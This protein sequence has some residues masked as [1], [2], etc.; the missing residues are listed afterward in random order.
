MAVDRSL[1][2]WS[3]SA[4]GIGAMVGAGIFALL[5]QAALVAGSE[6]YVAF[7]LGGVVAAL[8]G[9]SYAKLAAHYPDAGGL[10]AYF[11]TA[12]GTGRV[13]GTLALIYLI[14]LAATVAMVAKAFGAYAAPLIGGD[15]SQLWINVYASGIVIILT[16]LNIVGSGLVGKA[17]IVLVGIK[18]V[19]LAGLMVAGTIGL[20]GKPPVAQFHPGITATI[21]CVGLTF[22][23]YAGYG[24]MANA[25]GSVKDPKRTMPRAIFL[26]IAMVIVLYVGLALIVLRSVSAADLTKHADTAVAEAARP[27]LGHIGYVVVSLGALIA[28]AS[29]INATIFSAMKI[30]SALAQA[31][32][33]PTMFSRRVWH[34]G[35]KG[36]LLAT[37]GV[38][39]VLNVFNLNA[40]A[41]IASATFLI[42][43]LAVHVAHWRLLHTTKGSRLIVGVGFVSM[44]VVLAFFLWSTAEEQPWAIGVI[45]AFIGGSWGAEVF[46]ARHA[47]TAGATART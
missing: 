14:T 25:A 23:A 43:Y 31:R 5:G 2:L 18:L 27:V 37:V 8:S 15:G 7:L 32:Q 11:D 9:Y 28:T 30:A 36:L 1:S 6:T 22:F 46:F 42:V 26:A 40:L 47:A 35:T 21:G 33:L 10:T 39:L 29:A 38:L 34:D 20:V 3:V 13:A 4:L 45:M 16:M 24:M 12:F 17:E 44:A 19:I 41:R